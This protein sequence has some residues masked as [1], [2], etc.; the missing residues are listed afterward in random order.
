M[1]K[2]ISTQQLWRKTGKNW[3]YLHNVVSDCDAPSYCT[4]LVLILCKLFCKTSTLDAGCLE[5]QSSEK[6]AA[7]VSLCLLFWNP[8]FT[9]SSEIHPG[10]WVFIQPL[11]KPFDTFSTEF[12]R[13][14]ENL[15]S[16]WIFLSNCNYCIAHIFK[17][18]HAFLL[19]V[20]FC[21]YIGDIY[22]QGIQQQ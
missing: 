13:Y 12:W 3:K 7:D 6:L 1:R 10:N 21:F 17:A 9:A 15:C 19:W 8:T 11:Q 20:V 5:T 4:F 2:V 22:I 16:H 18:F 14:C